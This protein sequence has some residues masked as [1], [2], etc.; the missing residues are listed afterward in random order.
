MKLSLWGA[1][2]LWML[3]MPLASA[4]SL[5]AE[6]TFPQSKAVVEAALGQLQSSTGGHLPVL[7][8]F[9]VPGEEPL[10]RFQKGYYQCAI[11]VSSTPSG[12]SQV[13]VTAKITAWY[14]APVAA[15]SE[16]RVLAS[17]GRLESDLLD[18]LAET[19]TKTASA[20][21]PAPTTAK[22]R[23]PAL[24]HNSAAPPDLPS[25]PSFT[26]KAFPRTA[27]PAPPPRNGAANRGYADI[28]KEITG[29]A[30]ILRNQSHPTNL[31]AVRKSGTPVLAAPSEGG[32]VLFLAD[33]EDE[34]EILESNES[35][36]HVRISGLSRAWI[37]RSSLEMPDSSTA[38]DPP[39]AAPP[40][41]P[42]GANLGPFQIE[43]EEVA[44]SPAAW[45]PLRGKTVRIVSIQET[46]G[47]TADSGSQARL[48]FAKGLFDKELT[49]LTQSRSTAA[50]LVLVFD[51]ADGG[52]LAVTMPVLRAWK[53]GKLSDEALWRRCYFDP[54]E[55]F[56]GAPGH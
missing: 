42:P 11:H 22:N 26:G 46:A 44:S 31:A 51:S 56:Q 25:A 39:V 38:E 4:Q 49:D 7:D 14:N 35:W 41:P 27:G 54:P 10:D 8:G 52:M 19:L 9:A 24:N 6:R 32:K 34:F 53:A 3:A 48:A 5:P 15:N 47:S 18:R 13:R 36:V 43:S 23:N 29:L 30:E 21:A 28:D 33:A 16:Y 12:G 17:N 45:E 1:A 40:A 50:G 37:R 20:P 55:M 2:A